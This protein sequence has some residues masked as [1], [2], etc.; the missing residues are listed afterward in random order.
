MYPLLQTLRLSEI[1]QTFRLSE[2]ILNDY[3]CY[4]STELLQTLRLSEATF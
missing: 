2:A 3:K 4:A 1:L